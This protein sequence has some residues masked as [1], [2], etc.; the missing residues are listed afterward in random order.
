MGRD[1]CLLQVRCVGPGPWERV[2][3]EAAALCP[4]PSALDEDGPRLPAHRHPRPLL[5]LL[6]ASAQDPCL[7]LRTLV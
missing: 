4:L 2:L 3:Q 5:R 1:L 6:G 7:H